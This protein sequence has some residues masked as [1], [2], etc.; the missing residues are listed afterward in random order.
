M[1]DEKIVKVLV[2]MD[3]IPMAARQ[4]NRDILKIIRKQKKQIRGL[5]GFVFALIVG[6]AVLA[7]ELAERKRSENYLQSKI[8]SLN[9]KVD[10]LQNRMPESNVDTHDE[11]NI[12]G[13]SDA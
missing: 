12:G 3:G 6:G 9:E 8:D 7:A 4:D 5:K 2:R 11:A 10:D 1:S 13:V